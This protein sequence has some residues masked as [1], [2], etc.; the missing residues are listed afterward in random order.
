MLFYIQAL[1]PSSSVYIKSVLL[2]IKL[3]LSLL[4]FRFLPIVFSFVIGFLND[5]A[6]LLWAWLYPCK[7]D[8]AIAQVHNSVEGIIQ[9]SLQI[10]RNFLIYRPKLLLVKH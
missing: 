8:G 7:G 1:L 2:Y 4:P 9:E 10:S 3:S 6:F 5:L